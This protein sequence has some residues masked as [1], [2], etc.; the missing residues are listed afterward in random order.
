MFALSRRDYGASGSC[1]QT[2]NRLSEGNR[3][4][5]AAYSASFGQFMALAKLI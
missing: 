3:R 2:S 5:N 4:E 1:G